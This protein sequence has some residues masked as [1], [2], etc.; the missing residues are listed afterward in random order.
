MVIPWLPPLETLTCP[1]KICTRGKLQENAMG[2]KA[3]NS[4]IPGIP[5]FASSTPWSM[6]WCQNHTNEMHISQHKNRLISFELRHPVTEREG[7]VTLRDSDTARQCKI[8]GDFEGQRPRFCECC[9][10][11][12]LP[13]L[14]HYIPKTLGHLEERGSWSCLVKGVHN[15]VAPYSCTFAVL[16]LEIRI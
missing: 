6:L 8:V 15:R 16:K 11:L 10:S 12:K 4:S 7:T 9:R 14:E 2:R 3:C 13:V 1:V 5:Y